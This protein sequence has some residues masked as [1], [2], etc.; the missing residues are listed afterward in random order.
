[1]PGHIFFKNIAWLIQPLSPEIYSIILNGQ[2]I[3]FVRYK[4]AFTI[5]IGDPDG[6]DVF[7][8]D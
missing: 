6:D 5:I 7:S 4:T 3:G 1:M 2:V 8:L